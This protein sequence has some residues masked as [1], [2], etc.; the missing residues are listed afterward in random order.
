[1]RTLRSLLLLSGA[2]PLAACGDGD[3]NPTGGLASTADAELL[4]GDPDAAP[5]LAIRP[6]SHASFVLTHG[7]TVVYNDP[8]GGAAAY[9]GFP[10]ADLVLVSDV[11]G[12]HLDSATLAAV[13][14]DDAE[15]V[16]PQAVADRL[17]PTLAARARVLANGA[18]ATVAGVGVEAVPMYNLREE[19][20]QFHP[21]GRGNGYVLTLGEERV[22]VAGDTED[23]PEMRA[24]AD[25][26]VAFVPM[27]LPY[28]MPA[29]AAA[30]AVLAFAPARAVP[31][32]FRGTE[33]LADT[34]AFRRL[35]EAGGATEV[36]AMD[37]YPGRAE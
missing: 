33:G 4:D 29:T 37:W 30:D 24:L 34:A 31:Y 21:K 15:L 6:V 22:Y 16:V 19:A 7:E 11:H 18:T 13:V 27:N 28:T 26:D 12:D 9:A 36:V 8:V 14:G 10:A 5:A 20:R 17:P 35:V 2:L 25:I 32:H 3:G 23:I 1:M